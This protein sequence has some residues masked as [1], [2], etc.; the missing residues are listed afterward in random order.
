MKDS[1]RSSKMMSSCQWPIVLTS[2]Q[3]HYEYIPIV[4]MKGG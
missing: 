3:E 4:G 1:G 2:A